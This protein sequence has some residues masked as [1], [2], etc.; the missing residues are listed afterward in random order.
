MDPSTKPFALVHFITEGGRI[1]YTGLL[2]TRKC[3]PLVKKLYP[4]SI[5]VMFGSKS[6]PH[7]TDAPDFMDSGCSPKHRRF[8]HIQ[9]FD[10]VR[11]MI[12][13]HRLPGVQSLLLEA[14]VHNPWLQAANET[15]EELNE[16]RKRLSNKLHDVMWDYIMD[17]QASAGC[18]PRW[19]SEKKLVW[20]SMTL[21]GK[22]GLISGGKRKLELSEWGN[23]RFD[24]HLIL[25]VKKEL[26]MR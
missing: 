7:T 24:C 13:E 19:S 3:C 1:G 11:A 10:T 6:Y 18:C 8:I 16:R 4:H 23:H 15:N 20:Q 5:Y 25:A 2:V 14:L 21:G 26:G 12:R 17:D 9:K 22:P